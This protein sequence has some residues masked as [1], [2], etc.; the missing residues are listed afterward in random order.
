VQALANGRVDRAP[1]LAIG[2]AGITAITPG[3]RETA[4]E[5]ISVIRP[6]PT[7]APTITA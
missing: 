4:V 5:S 2:E 6:M 3:M 1:V 7:V